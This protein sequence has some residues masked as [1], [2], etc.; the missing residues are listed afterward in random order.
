MELISLVRR[1]VRVVIGAALVLVAVPDASAQVQVFSQPPSAAGGWHKSSWYAPDGLDSDE[2]AW[3]SFSVAGGAAI[4]EVRWRGCYSY[5]GVAGIQRAPVYAFSVAIYRSI[6]GNS[7]PDMGTGGRLVRYVVDTNCGET[8]AGSAGGLDMYD[9]HYTLPAPFQAAAGTVYW[10]QIEASQG[11]TPNY[12]WPPDWALAQGSGG[13]GSYFRRITGGTFQM[14]TGDLAFS[15]WASAAPTVTITA[16]PSPAGTGTVT[17]AGAYPVNS[18]VTLDATP[19]TGYGFVNWTVGGVQVSAGSHYT[20]T[21]TADRVLVA[22]FAPAYTLTTLSIPSYGG[23]T[24][25]DG[26]YVGGTQ[27]TVTATPAHGFVFN[28]WTDGSPDATHTFTLSSDLWLTAMFQTDALFTMFD[29]DNAPQMTSLPVDLTVGG[30]T[31]HLSGTGSGFSVQAAN[32]YGFTPAGFSGLVLTPNSVFA[33]DLVAEFGAPLTEFSILYS[34]QEIGCDNSA[35]MRATAFNGAAEVATA[36]ATVPAPGTWPTGTLLVAAPA[37]TT[38]NRVVV[39]YDARPQTCQDWGPI[40]MADN[41]LVKRAQLP[42]CPADV[43]VQGG[44]PGHDRVLDNN[45][46]IVF[47][48]LFFAGDA[49]ADVGVQ[50]GLAGHDGQFDNNDFIAYINLFFSGCP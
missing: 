33:A 31:A 13:N 43:G 18:T 5:G 1:V 22:N 14:I 29:L 39:H 47:I 30:L 20:F 11:V 2:Y 49:A 44:V 6:P 12:F 48:N 45:D 17:G 4:T 38:F 25:G 42:P 32:A 21:A 26:T 9:Y 24:T 16:T 40:F 50:G 27:Q 36:T 23:T 15:L 8:P 28:G 37:G 34:P 7:Q 19:A 46:F 35:T 41:M 3:D 10:V